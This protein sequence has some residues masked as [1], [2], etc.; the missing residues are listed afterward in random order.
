MAHKGQ[1]WTIP[2]PTRDLSDLYGTVVALKK[3]AEG[4]KWKGARTLHKKFEAEL[5]NL[6]L[7]TDNVSRDG[8]GGRTW[9]TVPRVYGMWYDENKVTFTSAADKILEGGEETYTQM[10]HQIMNFQFPNSYTVARNLLDDG[11]KIFPYRF[12]IKLLLDNRVNY[13]TQGEVALFL[14]SVKNESEYEQVVENILKYRNKKKLDGKDLKDSTDLLKT[15]MK[16]YRPDMRTDSP[17]DV[18]GYWRYINSDF[19]NTF[20]NHLRFLHEIKYQQSSSSISILP[21]KKTAIQLMLQNYGE[22]HPF[23]SL[24]KYSENAFSEHYGLRYDRHKAT[25]MTTKPRTRSAKRTAKIKLAFDEVA[26]KKASASFD[27]KIELVAKQ[28]SLRKEEVQKTI[29]ENP[30]FFPS[31]L[32]KHVEPA[33]A[34]YYIKYAESGKDN[35]VFEKMTREIFC[36]MGFETKKQAIRKKSFAGKHEIDGL[37]LNHEKTKSGLLE[38]KSGKKYSLSNKDCELMKNA[39]IPKF[40]KFSLAFKTYILDFFVYVIGSKFTGYGNFEDISKSTSLPGA[41]IYARDLLTL[42]DKFK[43]GQIK[44]QPVWNLFTRNK[45]ITPADF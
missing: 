17:T 23:S 14:L 9:A 7:K 15:H 24:Y 3:I 39:Y 45:H 30:D 28:T 31:P 35:S 32:P 13:L 29:A 16:K 44:A 22:K 5:Q 34:E 11:F 42:Y 19:A 12:M 1:L 20:F 10:V 18:K 38:C 26:K 6:H 8:S 36:D 40:Q 25:R 41:I 33:F 43:S 4:K 27:E 21:S 2:R 37:I